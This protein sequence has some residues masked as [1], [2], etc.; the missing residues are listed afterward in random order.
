LKFE[1]PSRIRELDLP[2]GDFGSLSIPDSVEVIAGVIERLP[3][4]HRLL[5]F[6]RESHLKQINLTKLT[7]FV[8]A[9]D[10]RRSPGNHVF[11][12]LSEEVLRRFR[13]K[14]ER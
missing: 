2:P 5:S 9:R 8:I 11:V 10:M 4:R 13:F 12:A 1:M 7:P 3:G 6:G 14:F